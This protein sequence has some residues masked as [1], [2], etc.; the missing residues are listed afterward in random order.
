VLK[1]PSELFA[2]FSAE[3]SNQHWGNADRKSL[4][5][6]AL[7][8]YFPPRNTKTP[9]LWMGR[10]KYLFYNGLWRGIARPA[11]CPADVVGRDVKEPRSYE[12]TWTNVRH[13]A[14][15]FQIKNWP[16][17]AIEDKRRTTEAAETTESKEED[18]HSIP[19]NAPGNITSFSVIFWSLW[20]PEIF[21]CGRARGLELDQIAGTTNHDHLLPPVS[22]DLVAVPFSFSEQLQLSAFRVPPLSCQR[23]AWIAGD[24]LVE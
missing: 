13:R 9:P 19:S 17:A 1:T 12:G 4:L 6:K 15:D 11:D 23:R 16:P 24:Q 20:F 21:G 2:S 18:R 10:S 14:A 5:Q 7:R 22:L 8:R 3:K